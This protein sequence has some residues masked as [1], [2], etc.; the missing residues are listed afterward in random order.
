MQIWQKSVIKAHAQFDEATPL[1][2]DN[3]PSRLYMQLYLIV[4]CQNMYSKTESSDHIT[5]QT[6]NKESASS[7]TV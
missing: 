2:Y 4:V 3:L 7:V 5:T 1:A 6:A